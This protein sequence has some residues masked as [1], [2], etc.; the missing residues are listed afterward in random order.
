MAHLDKLVSA[1]GNAM[2]GA[3]SA[4]FVSLADRHRV[5]GRDADDVDV[6]AGVFELL[7]QRHQRAEIIR[8]F[9]GNENAPA[10]NALQMPLAGVK[11]N[12]E[13]VIEVRV[14]DEDIRHSHGEIGTAS[15]VQHHAELPDAKVSLVT[16]ARSPFDREVLGGKR[17]EVFV[18]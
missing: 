15:D 5:S 13:R 8:R 14:R 2:R 1:R 4:H 9:A 10:G 16:G 3:M 18:H 6:V 7:M 11:R 12:A 17:E